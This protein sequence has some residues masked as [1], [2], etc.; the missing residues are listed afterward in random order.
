MDVHY[1]ICDI[2]FA[3]VVSAVAA[4]QI[5]FVIAASDPKFIAC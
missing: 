5:L 2:F 1:V 3:V 4:S